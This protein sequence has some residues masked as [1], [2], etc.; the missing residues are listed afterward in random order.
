MIQYGRIVHAVKNGSDKVIQTPNLQSLLTKQNENALTASLTA[1]VN[2][3][4]DDLAIACTSVIPEFEEQTSR[5]TQKIDTIIVKFQHSLLTKILS[6][7]ETE[8][9]LQRANVH[10]TIIPKI[11]QFQTANSV[12]ME[13]TDVLAIPDLQLGG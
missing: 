13:N 5:I 7:N 8:A 11:L 10:Y 4:V 1:Q 12:D 9:L 2:F 6:V 3:L